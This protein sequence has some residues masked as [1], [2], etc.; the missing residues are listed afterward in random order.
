[1]K[2]LYLFLL[3]SLIF[4]VGCTEKKTIKFTHVDYDLDTLSL[5]H[6]SDIN[7]LNLYSTTSYDKDDKVFY[8]YNTSINAIDAYPLDKNKD[9]FQ[10]NLEKGGPNQIEDMISGIKY[11]QGN[12]LFIGLNYITKIDS[13][14]KVIEKTPIN[15]EGTMLQTQP[16]YDTEDNVIEIINENKFIF[17]TVNYKHSRNQQAKDYFKHYSHL[18]SYNPNKNKFKDLKIHYPDSYSENFYGFNH[19]FTMVYNSKYKKLFYCFEGTPSLFSLDLSSRKLKKKKYPLNTKEISNYQIET[20]SFKSNNN[21]NIIDYITNS[22]FDGL[23]STENYIILM[24]HSSQH[25]DEIDKNLNTKNKV[26]ELIVFDIENEVFL[27]KI[28]IDGKILS[29]S[30]FSVEDDIYLQHLSSD[31]EEDKLEFLKI[32]INQ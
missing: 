6:P 2:F 15:N 18:V 16:I 30:H 17:K 11:Y 32:S 27:D 31:K 1:M 5:A 7:F 20:K 22:N 24:H 10:I 29:N 12:F 14:G 8:G 25:I 3:A 28:V 26:R 9:P 23:A 13:N 19:R 4:I 21:Y